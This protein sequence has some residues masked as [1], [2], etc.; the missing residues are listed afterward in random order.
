[1]KVDSSIQNKFKLALKYHKENEIDIAEKLYKEIIE[2]DSNN[3]EAICYLATLYA[4]S[5]KIDLAKKLFLKAI[6][7]NPNNPSINNNL[8]NIFLELGEGLKS[9]KFYENALKLKPEY[10]DTHINL[11][12][13]FKSLGNYQKAISCFEKAIQ[14]EPKNIRSYNILGR[15]FKEQGQYSKAIACYEKLIKINPNDLIILNGVLD[16]FTSIQFSNISSNKNNSIKN[17]ILFLFKKNNINHNLVFHNAKLLFYNDKHNKNLEKAVN[18]ES[19]LLNERIFQELLNEE[20]IQL[21]LQKSCIRD[22]LV[23]K[24]L[25]KIRKEILFSL[26]EEKKNDLDK[27][28]N[29]IISLAEQSFLNEYLFFQSEQE[30]LLIR[31]LEKKIIKNTEVSEIEI[32]ILASY[33]PLLASEGIKNK[34]SNYTSKNFLFEDLIKMQIREP[35]EELKYKNSIKSIKPITD[36][37]SKKVRD[38][39]EE[40]PYPRWRYAN[41]S[42]TANFILHLNDDIRPNNIKFNNKFLNPN[43]LI[44]GCGT[45][46]QLVNA[47]GYQNSKIL[48]VDL[49][50]ASLAYAKRKIEEIGIKNIELLQGDILHLKDLNEK[51]DVI[52]CG[53]V[54]HHMSEPLKGLKILLDLLEP[55]GFLKLGLYSE[56]A[57]KHIIKI[58]NYIK[59]N[60][61][62][63]TLKDI[64]NCRESIL[65]QNDDKELHKI[66]YNNDFYSTSNTRDLIFH[67]QEH[68]FTIPEIENI[69]KRFNL[70]F[71]GFANP[72][73]KKKY[74]Q[75]FPDDKKNLSLD[76]WSKFEIENSDTFKGMYQFW[77][78]KI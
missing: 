52:E 48:G 42:V 58:R 33:M 67:V 7:I 55:H 71:L 69:I 25:T 62:K 31:D 65:N 26:K 17:L 12:I 6:E 20:I 32:A 50:L 68:R 63:N 45:G 76:N 18:S 27:Y 2:S 14:I 60:N 44:A 41:K 13:A 61:Y 4:Q 19:I 75:T 24:F 59:K 22:R 38:Q 40:N 47:I 74:L 73:F 39:Y 78:R 28:C 35:I 36:K 11:G 72:F 10:V 46:Q 43:I 9:I 16:L 66:V 51:F 57:R 77:V 64:R 8:G 21:I 5:K 70:E 3:I 29:F 49:S 15:V 37:V 30:I 56:I 1:M 54:L 23:E 53:G 34:L